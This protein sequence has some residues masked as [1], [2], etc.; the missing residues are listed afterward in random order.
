MNYKKTVLIIITLLSAAAIIFLFAQAKETS[1]RE[2]I[3]FYSCEDVMYKDE[4]S[5]ATL[6]PNKYISDKYI[7]AEVNINIAQG[8]FSYYIINGTI[9]I[10]DED[11]YV[12]SHSYK[13]YLSGLSAR[14]KL[15]GCKGSDHSYI[16]FSKDLKHIEL[17]IDSSSAANGVWTN[18]STVKEYEEGLKSL[19]K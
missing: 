3:R 6:E 12:T 7:D 9:K 5:E 18:A 10:G 8:A 15:E 13:S 4:Q 14:V 1:I 16:R 2:T 19:N 11:F 17:L